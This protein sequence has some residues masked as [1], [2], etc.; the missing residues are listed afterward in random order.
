MLLKFFKRPIPTVFAV[1]I[2]IA[3]LGWIRSVL[4]NS[5]EAISFDN[6]QMPLFSLATYLLSSNFLLSRAVSFAI[7][8]LMGLYLIQINIKHILVKN[9]TYLPA[10]FYIVICSSFASLQAINPA[11]FSSFF[12]ILAI[13]RLFSTNES[14][15]QLDL[16]FR[17]SINASLATLFYLPSAGFLLLIF[18]AILVLN[19]SGVR[20][21]LATIMGYLTP[22]LFVFFYYFFFNNDLMA[23]PDILVKATSPMSSYY[24]YN[25][26]SQNVFLIFL[27]FLFLISLVFLV[28]STL[29][30][31]KIIIR[32]YYAILL[33]FTLLFVAAAVMFSFCSFEVLFILTIPVSFILTNFFAV[34]RNRFWSELLFTTIIALAVVMLF[35]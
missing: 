24:D 30:S 4:T 9:R 27:G 33:W 26:I 13:D 22:W 31:Q 11:V 16:F 35:I 7:V 12:L 32:R 20:V 3:V 2:V 29:Q 10:F 19:I 28:G 15:R 34:A 18:I 17:A 1:I 25:G 21:W 14:T 8:L 23:I 6:Y 5:N